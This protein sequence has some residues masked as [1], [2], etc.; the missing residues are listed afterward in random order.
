MEDAI[1]DDFS[2]LKRIL[3][4]FRELNIELGNEKEDRGDILNRF[5]GILQVIIFPSSLLS[6]FQFLHSDPLPNLRKLHLMVP[7]S[8]GEILDGSRDLTKKFSS[9]PSPL[10]RKLQVDAVM[11]YD[12]T[13]SLG[14]N[15]SPCKIR[16]TWQW[17]SI[18]YD[19]IIAKP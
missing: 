4:R 1:R 18:D 2:V 5:H 11:H 19:P 13:Y 14:P 8:K 10:I 6:I 7:F 9:F 12:L 16:V 3:S 15:K 17:A